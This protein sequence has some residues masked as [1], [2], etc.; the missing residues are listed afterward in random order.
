MLN[1]VVA[2]PAEARPLL[3]HFRLR[4]KQHN[5]AFPIY[6][7]AAMALVVSGPGKVAA[8]AATALLAG[9][10]GTTAATAWLNIGIAGHAH[11]VIGSGYMAHR[12]TDCASAIN[13]YPPQVHDLS[14]PTENLYTVDCPENDYAAAGL[15]EMEAS[16]FF[17]VASRFSSGE[18]VQCF[19]VISDNRTQASTAVTAKL[20][21]QLISARLADIEQLV[22]ALSGMADEYARWHAP[23]PGLEQVMAHWHFTVS[24]QHQLARLARRWKVLTTDQP[25]WLEQLEKIR[26]A[27]DALQCLEQHLA[28]LAASTA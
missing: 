4:D 17:P 7:N 9:A 10:Q 26:S 6:R 8:A 2:L 3:D 20:C 15:Y 24:Q 19:K 14:I 1:I 25:L 22:N 28:A 27:A 11:H 12:I 13:W 23:H 5:T 16:G 18:L 21:T